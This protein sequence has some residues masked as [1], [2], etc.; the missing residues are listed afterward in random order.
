VADK[1][2]TEN[3][4]AQAQLTVPIYQQG[5]E[6]ASVRQA[7]H[8]AGQQ[9]L[10]ADQARLDARNLAAQSWESLTAATASIDSYQSQIKANEIALEGVQ[11][12]AEVGSRTVL[13]VLNAEQTLLNSR[14][15]LVRSQHDQNLAAHQVLS[16]VGLL[17][18]EG[19]GLQGPLYDP[20]AHYNDVEYQAFGTG[21]DVIKAQPSNAAPQ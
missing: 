18:G 8:S 6:Y 15:S 12:E 7:K 14:V 4:I 5:A 16:V 3:I 1:S 21:A 2:R 13:D 20:V 19:M 11:R 10:L 17:T 9:H